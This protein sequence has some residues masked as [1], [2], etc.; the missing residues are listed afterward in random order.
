MTGQLT[1]YILFKFKQLAR[2]KRKTFFERKREEREREREKDR[3]KERERKRK[4]DRQ[5]ERERNRERDRKR[6]K[7]GSMFFW[8]L[9]VSTPLIN[10]ILLLVLRTIIP[11]KS[12]LL[13]KKRKIGN[14][15]KS[16][17]LNLPIDIALLF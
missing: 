16:R 10:V 2:R 4:R 6:E 5:T 15:V 17:F 13:R 11:T 14:K 9:C 1:L 3:E 8:W 12:L 7:L